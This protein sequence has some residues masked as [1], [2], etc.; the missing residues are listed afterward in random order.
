MTQQYGFIEKNPLSQ[1]YNK[2]QLHHTELRPAIMCIQFFLI[3]SRANCS[4]DFTAVFWERS[5]VSHLSSSVFPSAD[6][7]KE[8]AE[9]FKTKNKQKRI[10]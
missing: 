10:K 5:R 9:R 3:V 4:E 2:F 1:I 6:N 8:S 7:L